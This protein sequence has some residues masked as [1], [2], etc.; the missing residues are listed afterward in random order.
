MNHVL[1]SS[2]NDVRID[3][4]S[5]KFER[6]PSTARFVREAGGFQVATLGNRPSFR[7]D[8]PLPRLHVVELENGLELLVQ[9]F[10]CNGFR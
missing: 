7:L 6:P 9:R 3:I 10:E 1:Q 2:L 4:P 8:A 5:L